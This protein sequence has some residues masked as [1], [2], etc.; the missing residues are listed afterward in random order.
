MNNNLLMGG[1]GF[2]MGQ[3]I[4]HENDVLLNHNSL[5]DLIDTIIYECKSFM[6]GKELLTL[7]DTLFEVLNNFE[8]LVNDE[9]K[10]HENFE[11]ENEEI[12]QKYLKAITLEGKS[13][14][15]M[16]IYTLS[17]R[18]FMEFACKPISE[19][20]T[21]DVMDWLSF[22]QKHSEISNTGLDNHRRYLSTI[23]RW[24]NEEGYILSNPVLKISK[25]RDRKK[26]KKPFTAK[27]IELL[28]EEF[29]RYPNTK[30]RDLAMFELLL[31]SGVRVAELV[32]LNRN[33][34]NF[35][36]CSMIVLG[37]GN[38]QREA[39][40]NVRAQ[41]ALEAYLNSRM[42]DNQA[43]FVSFKKPYNRIGIN[44]IERRF[45][46]AG[47]NVGVKC[48]PHKFRR[49]MATNLLNKGVPIEQ[50]QQL[51]GHSN[52]DTTTIYAQVDEEQ[53]MYNH[54]RILN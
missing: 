31:S 27:E 19:V 11:E 28:R 40:F 20:T 50:V 7:N 44:G 5:Q 2:E 13:K 22:K 17:Y 8:I 37:K 9:S 34:I 23:F 36:D 46:L 26:V 48:H 53:L 42:D 14:R 21:Q 24:F 3:P 25:L 1:V 45:R 12:F 43:L 47:R 15:T 49:T 52:L 38:K 35:E 29:S 51:L 33:D 18:S 6:S 32:N 16:D 41:T 10:R 39:Y 30:L 54:R 4:S